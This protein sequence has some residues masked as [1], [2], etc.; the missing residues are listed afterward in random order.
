MPPIRRSN[1]APKPKIYWEPTIPTPRRRRAPAFTIYTEAQ[2]PLNTQA[3]GT[4]PLCTQA[5]GTQALGTNPL[6]TQALGT[7]PLGTNPLGT[8]A[9][10]TNPLGTQPLGT[11]PLGTQP[12]GTQPLGTQPLG[13]QPLGT[14]PLGT[15]A[16]KE[17]YQPYFPPKDRAGKPQNMPQDTRPIKLF[18][19]F[20]T[21]KEIE[22]IVKQTNQRAASISFKHPWKPLTTMGAYRYLGCLVYMGV[23]PLRELSDYW[24]LDTPISQ[25]LV[26][27]RFEQIRAA[28]TIR[29][30]NSSPEQPGEPWWFRLEPLAATIR[31]ACQQYWAP[32]AHLAI[33][34][35]MVPYF[36][37]TRHTIKA[38]H[39]PIKQGYKL[40]ALG[41]SGYIYNWLWYSKAEGTEGIR[42]VRRQYLGADTQALVIHLAK[43]LPKGTPG[44]YTLYLDNL[45]TNVPLAT[46]LGE[47]SIGVMGTTRVAALGLPLGLI[48]LKQAKTPLIWGH[49][50]T[51]IVKGVGCF[52]WQ[53]NNR[54]LGI[55][56]AY[57]P[58]DTIIRPRKRPSTTS[59]SATITR[60]VFGDSPVKDL[61]IPAPID[62][63]NHHMGGVDIANQLRASFT[64]LRP[65]NLRYWKPLFYW[66]LD[67]AL[68]NSYLLALAIVGASRHHRDHQKYLEALAQALMTYCDAPEH[69]QIY[70]ASRAYCAYCRNISESNWKP[71]HLQPRPRA[72]GANITNIRGPGQFQGQ[73]RGSKTQWGCQECNKPLCKIGDCWRLWHE[74]LTNS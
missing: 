20:F 23:Q 39:K 36:G 31:Q 6:G 45:F 54:V 53:D 14:Q 11:Q 1:R 43:S 5:L 26:R 10:G 67:I 55:T 25:C 68:T 13:T 65:Q 62:A 48:Q 19:L 42:G 30:P 34:E 72:F 18:Q 59:T 38:P 46:A 56:T 50:E 73:F 22:N 21:V 27:D 60:P 47:L 66:L 57:N 44:D 70:R 71:K 24:Q 8:Q 15:H 51:T 63:Y 4:N 64:T 41:D 58:Q 69:T 40:W 3:L 2:E 37:H 61:P 16:P 7:Q 28:F 35:S 52:L 12:L 33:D 74:N 17:A 9:L 49:L 32:G 29:D